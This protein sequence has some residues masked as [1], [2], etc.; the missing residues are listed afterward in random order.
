MFSRTVFVFPDYSSWS[1]YGISAFFVFHGKIWSEHC[2]F[3]TLLIPHIV[4]WD[5]CFC[6]GISYSSPLL[7]QQQPQQQQQQQ[8]QQRPRQQ[9]MSKEE[10]EQLPLNWIGFSIYSDLRRVNT[11]RT[12]NNTSH[13]Y[14]FFLSV[15]SYLSF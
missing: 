6:C 10:V 13:P 9:P 4:L 8:Q 3:W 15:T 7:P 5:V 14:S 11:M 1:M 12:Q 2:L